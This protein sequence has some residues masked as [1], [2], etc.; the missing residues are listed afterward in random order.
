M[1][2]EQLQKLQAAYPE[3]MKQEQLRALPLSGQLL[4]YYYWA[5]VNDQGQVLT[6]VPAAEME[7][8]PTAEPNK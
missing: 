8:K 4:T 1:A 6:L 2:K 3:Q 7:E 5:I